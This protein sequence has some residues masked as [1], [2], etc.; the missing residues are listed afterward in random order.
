[1]SEIKSVICR[2]Y[3][4][5]STAYQTGYD[6]PISAAVGL[7]R[8]DGKSGEVHLNVA[9]APDGNHTGLS[10]GL[11]NLG[12][13]ESIN[14]S[15]TGLFAELDISGEL[16]EFLSTAGREEDGGTSCIY[17]LRPSEGDFPR[18]IARMSAIA[19]SLVSRDYSRLMG[20]RFVRYKASQLDEAVKS[21]S[22]ILYAPSLRA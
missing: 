18:Y 7:G 13:P 9:M 19:V 1:M 2:L 11:Y 17:D 10:G 3:D 4:V 22:V 20:S 6:Y 21:E 12:S 8:L 15:K 5:E 16:Y 14:L